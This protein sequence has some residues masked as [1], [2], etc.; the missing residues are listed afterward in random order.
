MN[1]FFKY[2]S[3][4]NYIR[5]QFLPFNI[6]FSASIT[7]CDF[8]SFTFILSFRETIFKLNSRTIISIKNCQATRHVVCGWKVG[9]RWVAGG[10]HRWHA[11]DELRGACIGGAGSIS[12]FMGS[13]IHH[14]MACIH[15]FMGGL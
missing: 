6:V 14:F 5:I 8:I 10:R 3:L 9:D 2:I 13:F 11:C 15:H 7:F 1:L 4:F 12:L